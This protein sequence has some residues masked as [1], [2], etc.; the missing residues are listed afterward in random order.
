METVN[1]RIQRLVDETCNGNVSE[2]ARRTGLKQ[3]TLNTI[4]GERKSKPSYDVLNAIA[5]KTQVNALWLLTGE[6]QKF[7]QD[8]IDFKEWDK[9]DIKTA[10][11][12]LKII[13]D[14]FLFDDNLKNQ[15]QLTDDF[16]NDESPIPMPIRNFLHK[17]PIYERYIL[18]H[19]DYISDLIKNKEIKNTDIVIYHYTSVESLIHILIDRSIRFGNNK[20]SNDYREQS[21]RDRKERFISF[22]MGNESLEGYRKPRMW[23]QYGKNSKGVCIGIKLKELIRNNPGVD[24]YPITY[25]PNYINYCTTYFKEPFRYKTIDWQEESEYRFV[26]ANKSGLKINENC[27]E[28][29][30]TGVNIEDRD[31]DILKKITG[32]T[33]KGI[34]KDLAF[35]LGD[36]TAMSSRMFYDLNERHTHSDKNNDSVNEINVSKLINYYEY[37]VEGAIPY[38]GD[39]LVSAGEWDLAKIQKIEKPSGWIKLPEVFSAIGA[40]PVVGCSMEP[41]IHA[42]DFIAVSPLENWDRIDPDKIYMIITHDDRMIKH[43]SSD[44]ENPDIL[45]CISPNYPK[46]KIFKSEVLSILKITFHGKIM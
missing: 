21:L 2:F 34:K 22:C 8:E 27:V 43:L 15:F 42:G 5:A 12:K 41:D 40:F 33:I 26:S 36:I 17:Y 44:E 9:V 14:T 29:I 19:V 30:I 37:R 3:P 24:N 31:I 7:G 1:E 18:E 6:G 4:L 16:F 45:W 32:F 20:N 39:L 35:R 46:F 10:K 38:Y 13:L 25:V 28:H 23:A 11:F